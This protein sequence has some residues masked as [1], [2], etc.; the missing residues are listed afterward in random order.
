MCKS[1]SF[2]VSIATTMSL[3]ALLALGAVGASAHRTPARGAHKAR[4]ARKHHSR[5]KGHGHT[6]V[7]VK[8]LAGPQG[9]TGAT[10][11][12]GPQGP[13]G[14]Q[15]DTG[16]TGAPGPGAIEHTYDSTAPAA[17]EQDTPL[18]GAGPF[19]LT[20]SCVQLGPSLI[21]VVLGASNAS[22]VQF[23]E[24][25][26]DSDEGSPAETSFGR[27]SASQTAT[28]VGLFGMASTSAGSRESYASGRLTVTSPVHGELE[29]FEYVSEASNVCHIS[30][31][32]TPAS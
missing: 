22:T 20:G 27:E 5:R 16:L 19:H 24:L 23:D 25:R 8:L 10:G 9:K 32:W 18:G 14:Q 3:L 17:T 21:E 2:L 6:T 4:S 11:P 1:R 15:G 12:T 26:T 29:V 31:V 13:K 30:A 28:P 7:S